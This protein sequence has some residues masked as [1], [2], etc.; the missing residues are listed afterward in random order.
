MSIKRVSRQNAVVYLRRHEA[1]FDGMQLLAQEPATYGDAVALLAVHSVIS[2]AD[3]I[4]AACK[5]QRSVSQDHRE[6]CK[7]LQQLCHE[8]QVTGEGVAR[9]ER[10]IARKTDISYGQRRL[11][12]NRDIQWAQLEAERFTDWAL[13]KFEEVRQCQ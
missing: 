2:L 4:L 13:G 12:I 1:Y 10:L 8:R 5:G 6:S 3:A 9:F 7:L 11:N